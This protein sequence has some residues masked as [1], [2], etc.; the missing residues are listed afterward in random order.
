MFFLFVDLNVI[1]EWTTGSQLGLDGKEGITYVGTINRRY[2]GSLFEVPV[3]LR[4]GERVAVK[5]FR[6]KISVAY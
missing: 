3:T 5:A 6:A 2:K 1:L 4:R